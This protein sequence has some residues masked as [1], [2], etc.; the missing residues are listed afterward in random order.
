MPDEDLQ[1]L[2]DDLAGRLG[3]SV[4][5]D[6]PAIRLL[7]ASRH[8]G[9]EDPT[10]ITSVLNRAV[11][12]EVTRALLAL[13]IGG[14]TRPGTV[15]LDLP[16][17]GRRLCAPVRCNTL[18]LGHLWL[19]DNEA[20]PLTGAEIAMAEEAASRAGVMLYARLLLRERTNVRRETILRDL[21][22]SDEELRSQAVDDL[23]AEQV[24]GGR[25]T[26]FQVVA[27]QRGP[28]GTAG[29]PD[30]VAVAAAVQDGLASL[31]DGVGLMVA[32]RSR[33]WLLLAVT[34]DPAPRRT[35]ALTRTVLARFR[36]LSGR[37]TRFVVGVSDVVEELDQVVHAHRQAFAAA[38]AALL[39]PSLGEVASWGR[40]GV[41]DVLLRLPADE[42]AAAAR[43]P[44]LEALDAA[45]GRRVL[46]TTLE[47]YLDSACDVRRAAGR[48]CIHR[49]TLYH[50][51]RRIEEIT[52]HRLDDGDDRLTLHL[53]L[54]LRAL[55]A[56]S[57]SRAV[58]EQP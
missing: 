16:G 25:T 58:G 39:V 48:L 21:V 51:L 24:F 33:A 5:I 4:A 30:D 2:V 41:H 23:R 56:S 13:G 36:Q 42:L 34:S 8:F 54:K 3:R 18:L 43:V 44:A 10:R 52:D 45:D 35:D 57:A 38:R 17:I 37:D 9:D 53:G 19:I 47:T 29:G 28:A 11:S 20:N 50:R 40:L 7:A 12:E 55:A 26:G 31:P 14:W 6:D 46:V 49:A 32:T 22:T 15:E 27:A 1:L